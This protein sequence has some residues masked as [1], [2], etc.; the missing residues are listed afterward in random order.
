[1][2]RDRDDE[3]RGI[4]RGVRASRRAVRDVLRQRGLR[5]ARRV[6]ARQIRDTEELRLHQ[7]L[8]RR[9]A[10]DL[11]LDG[12]ARARRLAW[13]TASAQGHCDLYAP[14]TVTRT[15]QADLFCA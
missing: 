7:S 11:S 3:L 10:L 8:T 9:R 14:V 12:T 5:A 15:G 2:T 1:Q 4:G 6:L 13:R